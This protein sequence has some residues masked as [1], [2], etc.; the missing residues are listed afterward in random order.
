M[1]NLL[2]RDRMALAAKR[3]AEEKGIS[4]ASA[5]KRLRDMSG[6][7]VMAY[8]LAE[9]IGWAM[10]DPAARKEMAAPLHNGA[11]EL[12]GSAMAELSG[13]LP[14]MA[15]KPFSNLDAA[16]LYALA[17]QS[18]FGRFA[19]TTSLRLDI[20][21]REVLPVSD[22]TWEALGRHRTGGNR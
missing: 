1:D 18:L 7:V 19:A 13:Q 10:R 15:S 12:M 21:V 14:W 3:M 20:S 8:A 17:D 11:E 9:Y 6:K 22:E 5:K 16:A 4:L 2:N